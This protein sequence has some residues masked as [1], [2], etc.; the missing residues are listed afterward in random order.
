LQALEQMPG[1]HLVIVQYGSH[2]NTLDEFVF[3]AADIDAAKVVWARDM[4]AS[5]N[6]ELLGYFQTRKVWVVDADS[7]RPELTPYSAGSSGDANRG[8]LGDTKRQ[9]STGPDYSRY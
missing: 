8:I 4:G 2:H 7:D 9:A 1:R 6:R 5:A 3:N